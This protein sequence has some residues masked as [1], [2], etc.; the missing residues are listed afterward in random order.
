VQIWTTSVIYGPADLQAVLRFEDLLNLPGHLWALAS[1]EALRLPEV[2]RAGPWRCTRFCRSFLWE[3][4]KFAVR[5][6]L[7]LTKMRLSLQ[8][9]ASFRVS[10]VNEF[11]STN[12]RDVAFAEQKMLPKKDD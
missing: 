11:R 10:P 8:T 9:D 4:V 6:G 3:F 7:T 1:L 5:P 2:R 12:F